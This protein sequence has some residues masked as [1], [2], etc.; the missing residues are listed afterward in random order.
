[1]AKLTYADFKDSAVRAMQ[2]ANQSAW[3]LNHDF[4]KRAPPRGRIRFPAPSLCVVGRCTSCRRVLTSRAAMVVFRHKAAN[5]PRAVPPAATD[6]PEDHPELFQSQ[7]RVAG[8]RQRSTLRSRRLAMNEHLPM[9][10]VLF[11]RTGDGSPRAFRRVWWSLSNSSTG[12]LMAYFPITSASSRSEKS[13]RA[14]D[15]RPGLLD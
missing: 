9:I 3:R 7:D 2:L 5:V 13:D 11:T 6:T 14:V 15:E 10:F 4:R 12:I 8:L 1:M